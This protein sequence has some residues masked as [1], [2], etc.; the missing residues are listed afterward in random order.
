M[1]PPNWDRLQEIYH[2]AL[3]QPRSERD[4]FVAR[5][6]AGDSALLG[7]VES[8]LKADD[9]SDVLDT[10]VM[11]VDPA[12]D[13]LVGKTINGRYDVVKELNG[14]GMSQVYLA[15]DRKFNGQAVVIKL[16]SRELLHHP[17]VRQKFE[18]EVE[19]L[20]HL[21]HAGVVRVQD[22]DEWNG[23][24]YIVMEYIDGDTLRSQISSEEMDLKRVA[25]ILKQIGQAL[26]HVHGKGI[27]HRDLKPANI[28]LKRG[29]DEVVL[30]DFGIAKIPGSLTTTHTPIGTLPY[31]SPEQ[32]NGEEITAA[33]DIYSMAVVAF[34]MITGRKPFT[35]TSAPKLVKR[36]RRGVPVRPVHLRENLPRKAQSVILRALS[37]DPKARH[38]TAKNFCDELAEA[39]LEPCIIQPHR[40]WFKLIAVGLG[41][42][43]L[44]FAVYKIIPGPIKEPSNS[45]T[46]FLTVQK[47]RDGK[48]YQEPFKS[49]GEEIFES[50]DKFQLTVLSPQPAYVY[51]INEGPPEPNDTNVTMIYPNPTTNNG[52]AALGANQSIQSDWLTF[53]GSAG[54][55]NF[56][57]VW[58]VSPIPLLEAAKTESFKHPRSG[59]TDQNLVSIKEFL[60]LKQS[61]VS[62][63]VRHYKETQKA[64]AYGKGDLLVT[65]AQFKHR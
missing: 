20:S 9:S 45:F 32:L 27:F 34:E 41:I 38:A 51:I 62:V 36:Q 60:R 14:G 42:A 37:F 11:T 31:M 39:L 22:R 53:A 43:L 35:A 10:P 28:M 54:D 40:R 2:S 23:R 57:I 29:S 48:Q 44:S 50:G 25:A 21:R 4:A 55:D 8:L 47:I 33:S 24:P 52:S 16:L 3:A 63:K 46:Y 13:E 7:H 26:D 6:C 15:H 5:E 64:I 1:K 19:A 61:E 30:V 17:H 65:L 56:W 12:T 49:N 59:L 18:N 58:S